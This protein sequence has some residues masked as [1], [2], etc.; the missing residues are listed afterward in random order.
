M[1]RFLIFLVLIM[2][3]LPAMAQNVLPR[4][5]QRFVERREGCDDVRRMQEALR[6][7]PKA[8]AGT[9]KELVQLKRKYAPNSTIMQILNQF[10][11][12][13]EAGQAQAPAPKSGTASRAG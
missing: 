2:P 11:S 1:K 6:D 5:V 12:A 9:D 7:M 10:E 4:D 3:S 13:I 8:C